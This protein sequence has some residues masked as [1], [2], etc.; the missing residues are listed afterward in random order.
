LTIL[1][2]PGIKKG[3]TGLDAHLNAK[4]YESCMRSCSFELFA[5]SLI[6]GDGEV[7]ENIHIGVTDGVITEISENPLKR[8]YPEAY[9]FSMK[10][11]MPGLIDAH[12]HIRYDPSGD[13]EQRSHEYQALRGAENA[14]KA[15]Y[16][17]V[18]SLGDAGA[19]GNVAFAV[20]NAINN[21]VTVGPR[22]FVS[23]EMITITGGRSKTPS[24]RLEVNG[25]DSAREAARRL[26]MY[27][28]ADYIKL[29][30]TGAISSAHTGPRHPQLTVDEM[31][32]CCEEAHNCGKLVHSHCYGEKGISN[33][34][35]AGCDVIVHG[36]TLNDAHIDY[37]KKNEL[38]LM[39][40]LK[41][42]CGHLDHVGEGGTHDRIVS[43][44]IWGETEPNFRRAHK[45]G[46]TIAMGTD[47]GMP[48]DHF[49]DNYRDLEYMV[50]WGMTPMEAVQAGTLNA[51]KS[52]A[53]EDTVGT[54][55]VG[56]RADLIVL[57]RNP[58]DD[59]RNI[60]KSLEEVILNGLFIE[61]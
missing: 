12:V 7:K 17:G 48:D 60:G 11:V 43:T 8:E 31:N 44:G 25:A 4:T 13:P 35:E 45:A 49:G 9:D 15:L 18:T 52:L 1:R 28:N 36:Q 3:G 53:V 37:M 54:I 30:A 55:E 22:L 23:G 19:V 42:F 33:S 24:E 40:T 56:K 59:I 21:G 29:G 6:T 27:H 46:L 34:L 14:R 38:I 39:P 32:A 61:K 26:L 16:S 47:A 58:L 57:G 10:T 51:A 5:G 20:R 41:A 2:L 50:E